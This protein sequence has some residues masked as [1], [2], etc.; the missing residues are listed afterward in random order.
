[1]Q[2]A[3]TDTLLSAKNIGLTFIDKD[4][5]D[6]DGKPSRK[7][8]LSD[9][10]FEIKDIII[11]GQTTGQVISLVGKSGVGKT[12]LIRMLSGLYIGGAEKT[13]EILVHHDKTPAPHELRPVKEGDMGIVFQDYYMPEH[14]SIGKMLYKSAKKNVDY[15]NDKKLITDAVDSY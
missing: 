12:Q 7:V 11:P 8:I 1:M 14:L 9:V 10:N 5:L 13:G 2:Y 15:K 3:K 4:K 6:K